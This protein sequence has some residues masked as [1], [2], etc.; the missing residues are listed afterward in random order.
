M[1]SYD[2]YMDFDSEILVRR[3]IWT[4]FFE[5]PH[6][7]IQERFGRLVFESLKEKVTCKLRHLLYNEFEPLRLQQHL[8]DLPSVIQQ[9][10]SYPIV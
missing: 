3:L 2:A 1:S 10:R 7:L 8:P 5:H 6:L 4:H 9:R